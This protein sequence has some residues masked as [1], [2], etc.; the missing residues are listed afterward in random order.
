M[1]SQKCIPTQ[2]FAVLGAHRN[3][4]PA[5]WYDRCV[6]KCAVVKGLKAVPL[7]STWANCWKIVFYRRFVG[8]RGVNKR[9]WRHSRRFFRIIAVRN[10]TETVC[11]SSIMKILFANFHDRNVLYFVQISRCELLFWLSIVVNKYVFRTY[12]SLWIFVLTIDCC[13]QVCILKVRSVSLW[14]A[15]F[16]QLTKW[17]PISFETK[18]PLF[19]EKHTF[20]RAVPRS[21]QEY[22]HRKSWRK[23]VKMNYCQF[24]T[25]LTLSL[26][27]HWNSKLR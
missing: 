17:Y 9:R 19:A 18:F 15:S 8:D 21:S 7:A 6:T 16:L 14:I 13:K 25:S 27:F 22:L 10:V 5:V 20:F 24:I 11:L 2:K 4:I 3:T 12:L 26:L 1:F 23:S